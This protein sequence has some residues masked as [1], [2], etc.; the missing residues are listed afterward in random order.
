MP[1]LN[2][3]N[4][5]DAKFGSTELSAVY[6][7]STQIYG[8][9]P[10]VPTP[11]GHIVANAINMEW[12]WTDD[13][14]EQYGRCYFWLPYES[15]FGTDNQRPSGFY[16]HPNRYRAYVTTQNGSQ[17]W[18]TAVNFSTPQADTIEVN[19]LKYTR[20]C[21]PSV[22]NAPSNPP[23]GWKRDPDLALTLELVIP[24]YDDNP[25]NPPTNNMFSRPLTINQDGTGDFITSSDLPSP[26]YI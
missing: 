12:L 10:D 25:I 16:Y 21:L 17:G 26:A 22:G 11:E 4:I 23:L 2:I 18:L 20:C 19:G 1:A 6:K 13:G 7:G 3:S 15:L 8:A 14:G 24:Y 9:K 5:K